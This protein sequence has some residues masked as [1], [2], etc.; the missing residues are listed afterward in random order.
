[1]TAAEVIRQADAAQAHGKLLK[2]T[3]LPVYY[4]PE[5]VREAVELGCQWSLALPLEIADRPSIEARAALPPENVPCEDTFD[6]LMYDLIP[7]FGLLF[8]LGGIA[9]AF[10]FDTGDCLDRIMQAVS[11]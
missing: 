7:T 1:M 3:G 4:T 9:A 2:A 8:L 5:E 6:A 11:R 10:G